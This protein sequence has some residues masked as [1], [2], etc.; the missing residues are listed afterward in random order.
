M[1][2]AE[3]ENITLYRDVVAE[4]KYKREIETQK[5][6]VERAVYE[7]GEI[8]LKKLQPDELQYYLQGGADW[9]LLRWKAEQ[10][11]PSN[12]PKST[13]FE[14]YLEI[15]DKPDWSNAVKA[16]AKCS[17]VHLFYLEGGAVMVN[18]EQADKYISQQTIALENDEL[19]VYEKLL[20]LRQLLYEFDFLTHDQ[21]SRRMMALDLNKTGLQFHAHT[22]G[23]DK[24]Q[25][26]PR[27]LKEFLRL[28]KHHG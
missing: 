10:K 7:F 11:I 15:L 16:A 25:F 27:Q 9:C 14:R 18:Q 8:G 4:Q 26:D 13:N 23:I 17:L 12:F 5:L 28:H 19:A 21:A 24:Y 1:R 3:H 2:T 6:N 22:E 20:Q